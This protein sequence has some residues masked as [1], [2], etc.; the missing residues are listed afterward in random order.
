[1]MTETTELQT[2]GISFWELCGKG[3]PFESIKDILEKRDFSMKIHK[4]FDF[5]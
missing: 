4:E 5:C 2:Q 3:W 1:M